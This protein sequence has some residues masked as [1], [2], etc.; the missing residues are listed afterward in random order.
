MYYTFFIVFIVFFTF[1]CSNVRNVSQQDN[2]KIVQLSEMNMTGIT[3]KATMNNMSEIPGAWQ[4][5]FAY[6]AKLNHIIEPDSMW[7]VS[8][9]YRNI[10][11]EFQFNYMAAFRVKEFN[12]NI[13][14]ISTFTVPAQKYAVFVH[15]GSVNTLGKTY[16]YIMKQWLP[17]SPYVSGGI[18]DLE[19]YGR[20]FKMNSPKSKIYIYISL[21]KRA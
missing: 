1:N 20:D 10:N 9:N 8:Y 4:K 14:G 11:G 2:V 7:G 12:T 16:D 19:L 21:K 18:C 6:K 5:I 17:N 15:K 13:A 3:V